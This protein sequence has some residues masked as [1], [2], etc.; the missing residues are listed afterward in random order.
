MAQD[1]PEQDV[2]KDETPQAGTVAAPAFAFDPAPI[3]NPPHAKTKSTLAPTSEFTRILLLAFTSRY[4][5]RSLAKLLFPSNE[6]IQQLAYSLGMGIGS[7]ALSMNYNSLVKHDI[8]NIFCEAVA[9]EKGIPVDKVTFR[10]I[11]SSDNLIVKRTVENYRH[12]SLKRLGTDA[13]FFLATP[14]FYNK[15][16]TVLHKANPSRFSFESITDGLIGVKG[17]TALAETWN[18]KTTMFEDLVTFIN[19][20]VNPRNGL[21]QPI[22]TGE[23]FDLYQHYSDDFHP[24]KMFKNQLVH[25]AEEGQLWA[26]SEP[27]FRRIAELMNH[28]YAYKHNVAMGDTGRPDADFALPKF[29][30]LLGHDLIKPRHPEETHLAI[31]IANQ[32]GIPGVQKMQGMLQSGTPLE[33]VAKQFPLAPDKWT[34]E[35]PPEAPNMVIAKGSTMQLDAVDAPTSKISTDSIRSLE[36]LAAKAQLSAV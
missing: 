17:G 18:R 14:L 23:I 9:Y 36:T 24:D 33:Q 27:M 15:K 19:N 11:A 31:E 5:L 35:K 28:T 6:P 8:H 30:Y 10:D 22:T 12:R 1:T 7:T 20:K 25:T 16:L 29:I 26:K 32:Y 4:G 3:S 21:G 13:L 2:K 34:A